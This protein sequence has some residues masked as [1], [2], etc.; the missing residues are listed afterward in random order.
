MGVEYMSLEEMLPQCDILSLHC[1]LL[2]S[3]AY[4]IDRARC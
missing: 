3:T 4:I 1:P 2:P